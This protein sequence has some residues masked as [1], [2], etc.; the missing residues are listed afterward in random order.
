M[1]SINMKFSFYCCVI[2]LNFS[3]NGI[4]SLNLC[5]FLEN[6]V[7]SGLSLCRFKQLS[8]KHKS[9]GFNQVSDKHKK[10]EKPP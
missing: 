2:S 10:A 9:S 6:M 4:N 5:N 1:L 7:K 8:I 3:P